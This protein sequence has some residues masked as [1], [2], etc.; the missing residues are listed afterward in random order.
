MVTTDGSISDIP[1]GEYEEAEGRV[2]GELTEIGKPFVI[3]LNCVQPKSP[4]SRE[5]RQTMEEKYGVPVVAVNCLELDVTTSGRSSPRFFTS[6]RLKR[7][8]WSFPPGS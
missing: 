7:W 5:L 4:R 2:I 6:S 3:L 1:R 8:P